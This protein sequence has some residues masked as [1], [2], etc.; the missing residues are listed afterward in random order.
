MHY[1]ILPSANGQKTV[2]QAFVP[3]ARRRSNVV[4]E[5][6]SKGRVGRPSCGHFL[7]GRHPIKKGSVAGFA[8]WPSNQLSRLSVGC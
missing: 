1:Q 4:F 2:C 5:R 6:L 7:V 3:C 8:R